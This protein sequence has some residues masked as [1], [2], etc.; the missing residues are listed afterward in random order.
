[1]LHGLM[2]WKKTTP[3]AFLYPGISLREYG[4]PPIAFHFDIRDVAF[5]GLRAAMYHR[6]FAFTQIYYERVE[7]TYALTI[8]FPSMN[9]SRSSGKL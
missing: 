4:Q 1:V 3:R 7:Y 6:G 5:L 8:H 2:T 9:V